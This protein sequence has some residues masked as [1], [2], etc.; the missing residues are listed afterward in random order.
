MLKSNAKCKTR[1][2][3]KND[4]KML[5]LSRQIIGRQFYLKHNISRLKKNR[6][7]GNA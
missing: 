1:A 3:K 5:L 4:S 7:A 6:L 2:A